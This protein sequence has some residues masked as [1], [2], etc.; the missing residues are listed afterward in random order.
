M[1]R[2][3]R[4]ADRLT[5]VERKR[6]TPTVRTMFGNR[7]GAVLDLTDEPRVLSF[8]TGWGRKPREITEQPLSELPLDQPLHPDWVA[9]PQDSIITRT[10]ELEC[11]DPAKLDGLV[12]Y[13]IAAELPYSDGTQLLTAYSIV[14]QTG[15]RVTIVYAAVAK[16]VIA[17]QERG[18]APARFAKAKLVPAFAP[19]YNL[20]QARY[21]IKPNTVYAIVHLSSR[22]AFLLLARKGELLGIQN[23]AGV[24][25]KRAVKKGDKDAAVEIAGLGIRLSTQLARTF[26][27]LQKTGQ[28]PA[29]NEVLISD[30]TGAWE[31]LAEIMAPQIPVPI[32]PLDIPG[33]S[34][35]Q[36]VVHGLAAMAFDPDNDRFHRFNFIE[37][38]AKESARPLN[39]LLVLRYA[40]H[41]VV[42]LLLFLTVQLVLTHRA[43]ETNAS[44]RELARDAATLQ[45]AA[46]ESG[47]LFQQNQSLL[48]QL[49]RHPGQGGATLSQ[50]TEKL[51]ALTPPGIQFQDLL[52]ASGP[53]AQTSHSSPVRRIEPA[54][55]APT[56]AGYR[57]CLTGTAA[58]AL[59]FADYLALLER[60]GLM[61]DLSF[62]QAESG[63]SGEQ[64]TFTIEGSV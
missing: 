22:H 39:P 15:N 13:S 18:A 51:I 49:D 40:L 63:G 56:A 28:V 57:V 29:I 50:F 1:F 4:A 58:N 64:L 20:F 62:K 24:G 59:A 10:L 19:L 53:P 60:S 30:A 11:A 17:V 46:A 52:V 31:G 61:R 44:L 38:A 54:P 45:P 34:P 9:I 25:A 21:P 35:A 42:I 3:W 36:Y 33:L 48:N 14:R 47:R 43:T 37:G 8:Q 23:L 55:Q 32:T 27:D 16:N 7:S 5:S 12:H 6:Y 41:F 2:F 26:G